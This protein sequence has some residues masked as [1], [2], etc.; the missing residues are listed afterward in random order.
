MILLGGTHDD[1]DDVGKAAATAAT[2][3]HSIIN[4]ARHDNAPAVLIEEF[5]YNRLDLF[6]GYEIATANKHALSPL[7]F[8][9]D[10]SS[11]LRKERPVVKIKRYDDRSHRIEAFAT[12]CGL[13]T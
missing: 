8:V 4:R 12:R 7:T 11:F 9:S 2:L 5:G 6:F 13:P 3:L 10:I 1:V